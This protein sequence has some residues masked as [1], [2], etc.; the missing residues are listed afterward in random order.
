MI[1]TGHALL[2]VALCAP[3]VT[4]CF[5][6]LDIES[7]SGSG[8][9][10]TGPALDTPPIERPDGTTTTDPCEATWQDTRDMLDANCGSCHGGGDDG[11]RQGQPPF[12]FV[13]DPQKLA[14]AR[15]ATVPDPDDPSQGMLFVEPG[16][17]T[18][19]RIYDLLVHDEMP[20]QQPIGVEPLPRPTVSDQSLLN[21]WITYCAQ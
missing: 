6:D 5:Q 9:Q 3:L 7:V 21:A 19:S 14:T 17:P 18:K 2:L 1:R 13:L 15:S 10:P 12:D 11:A 16:A 20:P 8:D 4:A